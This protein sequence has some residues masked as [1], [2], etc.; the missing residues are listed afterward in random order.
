MAIVSAGASLGGFAGSN[1]LSRLLVVISGETTPLSGALRQAQADTLSFSQKTGVLGKALTRSVSLPALAGAAAM[2]GLNVQFNRSLATIAG[3]TPI[4]DQTGQSIDQIGNRLLDM[5]KNLP[6]SPNDLA[7]SFYFAASAGLSASEAFQVT[8]LSAKGMAIGMGDAS[9]ISRVLIA[10]LNNYRATGLTAADAMDIL[11]V[12]IKDGTAEPNELAVA[13]GRLLPVAKEA[14]VTFDQVAGSVAALTNLGVPTRVATTSL[15]ALFGQLLQPTIQANQELEALGLTAQQLRDVLMNNGPIAA[16]ELLQKAT[17][18]NHDQLRLLIPQI[19]A[20][21]AYFGLTGDRAKAYSQVLEDMKTRQ[22]AF[23]KAFGELAKTSSF[24][25]EVGVNKLRVAG[26][27]LGAKLIP[28]FNDIINLVGQVGDAIIALPDALKGLFAGFLIFAAAAGPVLKLVSAMTEMKAATLEAGA[29][30]ER[31][32]FTG[33]AMTTQ[34]ATLGVT[35]LI[36]VGSLAS[37]AHGASGLTTIFIAAISS[38]TAARTA[39][40]LLQ[41]AANAGAF[42][43]NSLSIGLASI[44]GPAAAAIAVGIGLIATAIAYVVGNASRAKEQIRQMSEALVSSAQAGNTVRQVLR[45]LDDERTASALRQ[46]ATSMGL[47]D[48]AAAQALPQ[49]Q[50]GIGNKLNNELNTLLQR[51]DLWGPLA[52]DD[53]DIVRNVFIPAIAKAAATG[54]SLSFALRGTGYSAEDLGRIIHNITSQGGLSKILEGDANAAADLLKAFQANSAASVTLRQDTASNLIAY[55]T[56]QAAIQELANRTGASTDYIR[57][58]LSKTGTT[59]TAVIGGDMVDSWK[60]AAFGVNKAG[61]AIGGAAS[62]ARKAVQTMATDMSNSL[63]DAFSLFGDLP[64]KAN[65]SVEAY[66]NRAHQLSQIAV[67]QAQ[68]IVNLQLKGIPAGLINQLV[69][70]GPAMVHK[71]ATASKP[72]LQKLVTNY[73][74]A[75]AAM[76][77]SILR[78]GAHQEVKGKNMIQGFALALF[79]NRRLPTAAAR[80]IAFSVGQQFAAG[81]ISHAGQVMMVKLANA[82]NANKKIPGKTAAA[83]V[84]YVADQLSKGNYLTKSGKVNVDKLIEG[85][86]SH[87]NLGKKAGADLGQ[88]LAEGL[89]SKKA[90]AQQKGAAAASAARTGFGRGARGAHAI[91]ANMGAE[92]AGGITSV[93]QQIYQAAFNAAKA[94]ASGFE[95]GAHN[96]PEYYTYYLGKRLID[97]L[98][99]GIGDRQKALGMRTIQLSLPKP[100]KQS[101]VDG[102]REPRDRV[103]ELDVK[104]SPTRTARDLQWAERTR[105]I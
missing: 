5:S 25:F 86:R 84:K 79:K 38:I 40:M 42:G 98:D 67:T 64:E 71:F 44:G 45:S 27:E 2:V 53:A 18:G 32:V 50:Q 85:I 80:Q 104:L 74:V 57:D 70:A 87:F 69:A 81:K 66:L 17:K 43:V 88:A 61:Q 78:E 36:A 39:L 65:K 89:D 105:G 30:G 15:R 22:D 41:S 59:A 26:I 6:T 62:E 9:D 8:E 94:A 19:R 21:T 63:T 28:I 101:T 12:A 34:I 55:N 54:R 99:R 60:M 100:S 91:G 7:K 97:D 1:V 13:L 102:R 31:M 23:N 35:S 56:E 4:L 83:I 16:F 14:G 93:Q 103:T 48:K 77:E 3:L 47:V 52:Q 76:D 95:A 11:T 33:K 37:L 82:L 58:Q 10:A 72:E 92:F 73:E 96:S 24:K 29:A 46:I 68:D 20:I 51:T 90:E 75:L 49:L